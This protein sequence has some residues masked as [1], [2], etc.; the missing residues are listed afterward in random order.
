MKH[1]QI[2][3]EAPAVV[4]RIKTIENRPGLPS[5][6]YELLRNG[7]LHSF[8]LDVRPEHDRE[9]RIVHIGDEVMCLLMAINK[10]TD[11]EEG[12][13]RIWALVLRK[14]ARQA[15]AW[16]R[17]GIAWPVIGWFPPWYA[18]MVEREAQEMSKSIG[19]LASVSSGTSDSLVEASSWFRGAERRSIVIV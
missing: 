6:R 4:A 7:L 10:S 19:R 11:S 15:G 16:E 1:A 18:D 13:L 9:D 14:S 3:V 12:E 8:T 5:T 2:T 17:V